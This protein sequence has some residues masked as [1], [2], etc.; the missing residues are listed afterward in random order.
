M[1]HLLIFAK[2]LLLLMLSGLIV[3][4]S[5]YL[6]LSHALSQ[7]ALSLSLWIQH[8]VSMLA[9]HGFTL[10]LYE[11]TTKTLLLSS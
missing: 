2:W 1:K 4:V 10:G 11:V 6:L 7:A 5:L 8:L 9:T 3:L